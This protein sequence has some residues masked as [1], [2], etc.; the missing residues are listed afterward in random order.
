MNIYSQVRVTKNHANGCNHVIVPHLHVS[1]APAREFGIRTEEGYPQVTHS[2]WGI[3]GLGATKPLVDSQSRFPEQSSCSGQ[4]S[5]WA[6][7]Q[8]FSRPCQP[9]LWDTPVS[10]KLI[11]LS[12]VS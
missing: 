9:R 10:L 2:L 5:S 8:G 7:S 6:P 12:S 1:W 4:N 3:S 11:S